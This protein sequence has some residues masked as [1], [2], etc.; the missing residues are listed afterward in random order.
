MILI[1]KLSRQNLIIHIVFKTITLSPC[2]TFTYHS[3]EK[4][5]SKNSDS[6]KISDQNSTSL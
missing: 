2:F 3:P 4:K 1:H 5:V 6:D